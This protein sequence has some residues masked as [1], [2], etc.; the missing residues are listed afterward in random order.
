MEEDWPGEHCEEFDKGMDLSA[1]SGVY[2]NFG[3]S[4]EFSE[5]YSV[6]LSHNRDDTTYNIRFL[7]GSTELM[8]FQK[9]VLGTIRCYTSVFTKQ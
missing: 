4:L 7:E 2:V 3:S 6:I 9:T 5:P 1:R 8:D